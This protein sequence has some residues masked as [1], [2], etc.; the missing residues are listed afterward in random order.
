MTEISTVVVEENKKISL[1]EAVSMAS[2]T[3]Y[4]NVNM[5][6][7]SPLQLVTGKNAVFPELATWN[8]ATDFL[9]DDEI[10]RKIK[11]W[12]YRLMKEFRDSE[13]TRKLRKLKD[14]RSKGYENVIIKE[15][16]LV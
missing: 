7:F 2:W 14:T 8:V 11:E 3:Y 15:G 10:G 6:G 16:E 1:Q 9:N 4:T 5:L 13:F 12:H